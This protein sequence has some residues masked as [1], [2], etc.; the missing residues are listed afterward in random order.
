MQDSEGLRG[1]HDS[2]S[3]RDSGLLKGGKV[4]GLTVTAPN[5]ARRK[6]LFAAKRIWPGNLVRHIARP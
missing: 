2:K 5:L 4:A 3:S 1:L 6:S